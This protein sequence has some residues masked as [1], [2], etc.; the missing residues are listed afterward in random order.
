[1]FQN[2]FIKR[3]FAKLICVPEEII[4]IIIIII[5]PLG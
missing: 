5:L 3:F 4:I 1:M 2:V